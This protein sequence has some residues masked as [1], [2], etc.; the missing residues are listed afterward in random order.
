M[1]ES[2]QRTPSMAPGVGCFLSNGFVP[3]EQVRAGLN[4]DGNS[5]ENMSI[6]FGSLAA[7]RAVCLLL[8]V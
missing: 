2:R 4:L 3:S 8:Q 1:N 6:E 7:F 5:V